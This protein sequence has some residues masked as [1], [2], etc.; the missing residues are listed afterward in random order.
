MSAP[1]D[2]FIAGRWAHSPDTAARVKAAAK[3][4]GEAPRDLLAV[5]RVL[6]WFADGEDGANIFPGSR[7]LADMLA[8]GRNH[9]RRLVAVLVAEGLLIDTG[10][11]RG[12]GGT[13]VFRLPVDPPNWHPPGRGQFPANGH[14]PELAPPRAVP[15][16]REVARNWR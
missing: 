16:P 12:R 4:H 13:P 10:Q 1:D 2:P 5:V 14:S 15:V 9:V 11:R 3:A 6:A 7:T 8:I